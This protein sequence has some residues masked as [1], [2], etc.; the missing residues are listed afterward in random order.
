MAPGLGDLVPVHL[1]V[2]EEQDFV[3]L[4]TRLAE[5]AYTRVDMVEKRGEYATRGGILDIFPP[6]AEHPFRVEFWGDEVSEIRPFSVQDQRSLP[7]EI[8]EF[9]APPCRELLLTDDVKQRAAELAE[10]HRSDA[11]LVE[12]LEKIS[13]GIAVEGME[14]LDPRAVPRRAAAAHRRGSRR[15]RTC[16]STT[17]RRSGPARP[18]PGT[19]RPG[20][21]RGVLDGG[22]GRWQGAD[23]PRAQLP[24]RASRE[25]ARRREGERPSVVDA[26]PA[27]QLTSEDVV[28][29]DVKPVEAY[30]GDVDA[31]VRRPA[32]AHGDRWRGRAGRARRRY[33]AARRRN[34]SRKPTSARSASNPLTRHRKPAT[35]TVV[36]GALEDGFVA[37]GP[38]AG[39]AHRDRPDRRSR[40]HVHEG[41]APDAVASGATR[42]TRW[43]SG[44]ATSWCT[45]STASA[46]TW[47][48][49]SARS[50]APPAS[51]WFSSTR[52][53][54]AASR[55]TGSS[56]RPTSSTRSAGTSAASCRR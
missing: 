7:D 6:T 55:A 51:T 36:R 30:Q 39:G 48:W 24:T 44:R 32:G 29:L 3:E 47:R 16:C 13:G 15:A 33:R 26:Q 41:H 8:T 12:M 14:A 17:R 18:R 2:G 5:N 38:R 19:D 10:E 45:S 52:A 4:V 46:S 27:H 40:R 56:C 1:K 34:S 49:C 21:P 54:S 25:I 42:S 35:V 11:H 53:A 43:R 23:R 22:R 31:R 28:H 37:A 50:R 9:V 20:V